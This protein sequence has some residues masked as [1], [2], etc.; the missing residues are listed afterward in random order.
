[1]SLH[2]H[3]PLVEGRRRQLLIEVERCQACG[4]RRGLADA[5]ASLQILGY[6]FEEG[7]CS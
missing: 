5:A 7:A 6:L 1:M 4:D 2:G 3:D